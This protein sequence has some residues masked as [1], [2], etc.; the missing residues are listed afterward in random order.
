MDYVPALRSSCGDLVCSQVEA[1]IYTRLSVSCISIHMRASNLLHI[2]YLH[3]D[4]F[5]TREIQLTSSYLAISNVIVLELNSTLLP[6]PLCL[7][8]QINYLSTTCVW[9]LS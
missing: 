4:Q 3:V 7:I 6:L 8:C 2:F 5:C 9:I 1:K